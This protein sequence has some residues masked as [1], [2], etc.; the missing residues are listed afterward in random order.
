M[1]ALVAAD[2]FDFTTFDYSILAWKRLILAT[3]RIERERTSTYLQTNALVISNAMAA[4]DLDFDKRAKFVQNQLKVYRDSFLPWLSSGSG[5]TD[6]MLD[7]IATWYA[8]MAPD[9]PVEE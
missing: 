3:R 9:A 8:V 7:D 2:A 6:T 1:Q 4:S 5:E